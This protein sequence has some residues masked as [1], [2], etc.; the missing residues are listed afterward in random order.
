MNAEPDLPVAALLGSVGRAEA[1]ISRAPA[2]SVPQVLTILW[3]AGAAIWF[4]PVCLG[5]WQVRRVCQLGLP[6]VSLMQ[7]S[8]WRIAVIWPAW[9]ASSTTRNYAVG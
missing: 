9:L 5:L 7:R 4:V 6:R 1:E 3:A 2:A 8:R